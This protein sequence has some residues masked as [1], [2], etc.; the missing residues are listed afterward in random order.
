MTCLLCALDQRLTTWET[1][2]HPLEHSDEIL[3]I[4]SIEDMTEQMAKLIADGAKHTCLRFFGEPA[5]KETT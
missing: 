4:R 2:P 1:Y 3:L 5:E